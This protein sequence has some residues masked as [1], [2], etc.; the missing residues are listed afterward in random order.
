MGSFCIFF[1]LIFLW[2]KNTLHF[3]VMKSKKQW[4]NSN[5]MVFL[6]E[7]WSVKNSGRA[8]QLSN[9]GSVLYRASKIRC[10]VRC[11]SPENWSTKKSGGFLN[12]QIWV[13]DI[14]EAP[15]KEAFYQFERMSKKKLLEDDTGKV[16]KSCITKTFRVIFMG[17]N[18][19]KPLTVPSKT[20]CFIKFCEASIFLSKIFFQLETLLF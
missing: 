5:K 11:F 3:Q 20:K 17:Q 8:F 10:F 18:P 16:Q 13:R 12:C 9:L 7:N 2:Y 6:F 1:L 4:N 14:F 19:S 15:N